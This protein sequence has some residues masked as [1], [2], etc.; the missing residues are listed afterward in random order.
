MLLFKFCVFL[1]I[2]GYVISSLKRLRQDNTG[3]NRASAIVAVILLLFG[4]FMLADAFM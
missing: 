4:I 2:V 1:S 3:K